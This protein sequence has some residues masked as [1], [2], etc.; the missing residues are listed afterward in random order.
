[1]RRVSL[2]YV[3]LASLPLFAAHSQ[4]RDQATMVEAGV[5]VFEGDVRRPYVVVGQIKDNLRKPFA[6][7][8]KSHHGQNTGGDLGARKK[9]GR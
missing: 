2:I 6:F 7:P 5:P 3:L 4:S 9:D 8:P 1:M